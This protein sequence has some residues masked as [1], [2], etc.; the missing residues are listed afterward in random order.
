MEKILITGGAGFIGSHTADLL[1]EQGIPVRVL[2]NL[3]SGHRHN[4]PDQHPLLE[5]IEG[6]I[7]DADTVKNAMKDV[8]HCL[9]LAAQVSVVASLEDPEFSAQQNILG[10]VN[11][12]EAARNNNVKRL[13]YASSAAIYGE[14]PKLPLDENLDVKQL[15]PYGLEKQI[16]ELYCDLYHRLYNFSSLGMRF[17]NVYGPRQD[18]KSPYA[19]V[20]ALFVD[21][22]TAN[23]P[24]TVFGD[25]KQTRDFI[26]VRDVARTNIAA[27]QNSYQGAC[28]VATG[29]QT[30]LLDL[31]NTLSE[32]TGNQTDVSFDEPRTGD[33]VHSLANPERMNK[34]LNIIADTHLKDGLNKLL[35]SIQ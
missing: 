30:S 14:P 29:K 31:I 26:Y 34:E 15:S 28:N 9:H 22:I 24:V 13:V 20:I 12:M 2:D 3:S 8:S 18:P 7:C 35:K 23:Q 21:R 27:L 1:M 4:L 32:L 33:I 5:F 16:N 19:G 10:F 25:G 17:F 6:D 11:V